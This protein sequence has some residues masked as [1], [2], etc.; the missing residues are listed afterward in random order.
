[1]CVKCCII[2]PDER[3]FIDTGLVHNVR[4][5]SC[6]VLMWDLP[7]DGGKCIS[8]YRVRIYNG[9]TYGSSSE[10]HV[11]S[12]NRRNVALS[13]I[14]VHGTTSIIVSLREALR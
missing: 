4:L 14:P 6:N 13:W 9:K 8:E 12:V 3:N 10:R 11:L 2:I 5:T 1:M 7:S